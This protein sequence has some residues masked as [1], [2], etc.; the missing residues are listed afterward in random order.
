MSICNQC[1][2]KKHGCAA[3]CMKSLC[4]RRIV[5]EATRGKSVRELYDKVWPDYP[6]GLE[7]IRGDATIEGVLEHMTA[8]LGKYLGT[9]DRDIMGRVLQIAARCMCVWPE[10]VDDLRA[11]PSERQGVRLEKYLLPTSKR[12]K[13]AMKC[14]PPDTP[15]RANVITHIVLA[16]Y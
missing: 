13:M 5:Y 3:G 8:G 14:V 12:V 16:C 2:M 6:E 7:K 4:E 10:Y 15:D 11:Y 9:Y 1:G